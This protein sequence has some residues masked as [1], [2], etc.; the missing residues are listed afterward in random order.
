MAAEVTEKRRGCVTVAVLGDVGHSPR[1]AYH[2]L[3]LARQ[4]W[5]VNLLGYTQSLPPKEVLSSDKITVVP[6]APPPDFVFGLP[7]LI[8]FSLRVIWQFFTLLTALMF[9]KE[10]PQ[11]I[12]LQNPPSVPALPVCWLYCRFTN[13]RLIVDWHNYGYTI[14]ALKF[15]PRNLIV[16]VYKLIEQ[17]FGRIAPDANICVSQAM[18]VDLEREFNLKEVTVHYDR[19]PAHFHPIS[20]G[21]KHDL[22]LR[23]SSQLPCFA[24]SAPD[25][26]V[27]TERFA[28]GRVNFCEDRPALLISSTSWTADEDF[29]LLLKAL[30]KYEN[31]ALRSPQSFPRLI[32]IITGKGP[33]KEYYMSRVRGY[34]WQCVQLETV[35]LEA[36]DY[37]KLLA[38][39]DLG[40]SLH[41]SSSGLDLPMKVVDMFGSCLPVLAL[42]YDTLS[43]L[44]LDEENGRLFKNDEELFKGLCRWFKG[45]PESEEQASN[46]ERFRASLKRYG[47]RRWHEYWC[48]N[49]LP[50]I[51]AV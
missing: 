42:S 22:F 50:L 25:K 37:P 16:Y 9:T 10:K 43:E 33:L 1:M 29:S 6:V 41:V 49:V 13:T 15:G 8:G 26:T 48:E 36:E 20:D 5:T 3:S 27:F 40:L 7:T 31:A 28:D 30:V 47:E 11:C 21:E 46:N 18:K 24:G 23:L 44:V 12:L 2:C 34:H 19:P 35:W 32:V 51:T 14:L 17:Y 45:F 38:A 4:G 39:S